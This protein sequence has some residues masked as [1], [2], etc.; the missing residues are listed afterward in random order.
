MRYSQVCWNRLLNKIYPMYLP[1][2]KKFIPLYKTR[3]TKSLQTRSILNI[4]HRVST[5][6]FNYGQWLLW[7]NCPDILRVSNG[8]SFLN[9]YLLIP[10]IWSIR[11]LYRAGKRSKT[12]IPG[13]RQSIIYELCKPGWLTGGR[14]GQCQHSCVCRPAID[15]KCLRDFPE[16]SWN[17][18]QLWWFS[19]F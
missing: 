15:S 16:D 3:G 10:T 9:K 8:F 5:L 14:S 11:G 4:S 19:G 18:L 7:L 12:L 6:T 13:S 2:S 17:M 1:M